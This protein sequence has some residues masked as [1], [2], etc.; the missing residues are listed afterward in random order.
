MEIAIITKTPY[1]ETIDEIM[2]ILDKNKEGTINFEEFKALYPHG[3]EIFD[4]IDKNTDGVI[5]LEEFKKFVSSKKLATK[6]LKR[7]KKLV[8]V[9]KFEF[10][11]RFI[12]FLKS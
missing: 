5:D 3:H 7:L 4:H 8:I 1:E 2:K 12:R 6:M 11:F 9:L 10:V